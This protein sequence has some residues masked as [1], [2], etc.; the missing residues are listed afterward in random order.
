[1][2]EHTGDDECCTHPEHPHH[3]HKSHSSKKGKHSP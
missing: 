2:T 3:H 1:M